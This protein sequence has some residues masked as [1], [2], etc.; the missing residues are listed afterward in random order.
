MRIISKNIKVATSLCAAAL[1]NL[2]LSPLASAASLTTLANF[3]GPNG[4]YPQSNLIFDSSGN[5]Y[6]TTTYGAVGW[7]GP[8]HYGSGYGEV[9]KVAAKTNAL[10][11]LAFSSSSAGNP[12][13][14]LIAD[15]VGNLFGATSAAGV[16]SLGGSV[17]EV[18]AGSNSLTTLASFNGVNG[19]S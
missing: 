5:L 19:Y 9:F 14:G 12:I 13:A 10:T 6:G 7:T 16:E 15:G 8:S 4:A 18:A 2:K 11:T 3:D 17:Y 1:L